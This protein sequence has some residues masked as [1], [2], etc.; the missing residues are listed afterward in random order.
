MKKL[1]KIVTIFLGASII[2][3]NNLS[4]QCFYENITTGT[5][6]VVVTVNI[7]PTHVVVSSQNCAYGYNFDIAFTY[8]VTATQN[9]VPIPSYLFYTL[10][11]TINTAFGSLFFDIPNETGSGTGQTQGNKYI[12][13]SNCQTVTIDDIG[14]SSVVINI[15]N[16][17]INNSNLGLACNAPLPIDLLYFN[18]KTSDR[19]VVL[20]WSTSNESNNDFFTIERSASSDEKDWKDVGRV[21]GNGN[22]SSQKFYSWE[23]DS[24]NSGANFYRLRQTDF[25]GRSKVFNIVSANV[26]PENNILIYPNPVKKYVIVSGIKA[27]KK[28]NLL[29]A[30]GVKIRD[31]EI[32][33][34]NSTTAKINM[35]KIPK[36]IYICNLS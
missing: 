12:S 36:G 31:L 13:N 25:D 18:A 27:D 29:S 9:G 11:G 21:K 33:Y 10:Q 30:Q 17:S 19:K 22:S 28:V 2:Y 5:D 32:E 20:H 8:D 16:A 34:L 3:I 15:K 7:N 4:G 14:I 24:P 6:G 1:S 23:D 35:E 26:I